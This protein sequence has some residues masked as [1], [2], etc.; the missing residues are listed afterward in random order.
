MRSLN[1]KINGFINRKSIVSFLLKLFHGTLFIAANATAALMTKTK[2]M[3][4]QL[5][6]QIIVRDV[7]GLKVPTVKNEMSSFVIYFP[8]YY[9]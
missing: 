4:Q 1:K 3:L 7:E 5:L 8:I 9:K 6:M 2:F